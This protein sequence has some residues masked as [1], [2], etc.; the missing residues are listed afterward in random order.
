MPVAPED[1]APEEPG[2][3]VL[4]GSEA[5]P[6]WFS[7]DPAPYGAGP[8]KGQ[9]PLFPDSGTLPAWTKAVSG[10]LLAG[11]TYG[12][13][14]LIRPMLKVTANQRRSGLKGWL[15]LTVP[16]FLRYVAPGQNYVQHEVSKG[17]AHTAHAPTYTLDL[18]ALRWQQ[19]LGNLVYLQLQLEHVARKLIFNVIPQEI[20]RQTTELRRRIRKLERGLAAD[21]HDLNAIRHWINRQLKPRLG[22]VEHAVEHTLPARIRRGEQLQART[23]ATNKNQQRS[24]NRLLPLLGPVGAA[25]L[26]ARGMTKLGLN[27]LRCKNVK[28]LSDELCASP[29]GMG[30]RLGKFLRGLMSFALDALVITHLCDVTKLVNTVAIEARPILTKLTT[31]IASLMDCLGNTRCPEM[32]LHGAELPALEKSALTL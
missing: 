16:A 5:P 23:T 13:E 1:I 9:M 25:S 10:V 18:M 26:V 29:P 7:E 32:T 6:R 30:S 22:H 27:Y 21:V 31:G 28:G 8:G 2:F 19:M 3:G 24:L 15:D 12:G 4:G 11:L 17:A 20:R 14:S